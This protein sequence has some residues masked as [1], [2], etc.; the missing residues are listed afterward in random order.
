M[1]AEKNLNLRL[2]KKNTWNNMDG[3]AVGTQT[4]MKRIEDNQLYKCK[5]DRTETQ[6]AKF[7]EVWQ[8]QQN[9]C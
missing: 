8:L 1:K 4:V 9:D 2:C 6:S 7:P 3:V 5:L